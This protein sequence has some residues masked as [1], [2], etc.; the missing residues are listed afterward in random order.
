MDNTHEQTN[1]GSC[2]PTS[3]AIDALLV[4]GTDADVADRYR[5][6]GR[7]AKNAAFELVEDEIVILDTETTG[8]DPTNDDLIEIFAIVMQGT[9]ILERF[10]TFVN[11]GRSIPPEIVELTGITDEDIAG[12]PDPG[13]AVEQLSAFVG[14][15]TVV[16]H[17]A[18]FDRSFIMRQAQA[19]T[20]TT[21]W[22]DSVQ[23]AFIVLPRLKSH[24][25]RD[26][27]R[28]Y[29]VHQPTHRAADD[30]LALA[31]VWRVLLLAVQSMPA[32]L[33]G[34]IAGLSPNTRWPL[35]PI[36]QRA[37]AAHPGTDCNLRNM[38]L[39]RIGA[40][41]PTTKFDAE[42]VALFYPSDEELQEAFSEHGAAGAMYPGYEQRAEQI[43]MALEVADAYRTHGLRAL[44]AGTGVGKSMA[45]LLPTAIFAK[46][47]AVTCGIATKTNAL[48][49]QL[50]YH[51]L[52]R[53]AGALDGL[54]YIAL[55]GYEHYPCLR[56]MERFAQ[57]N[58]EL[59]E[60]DLTMIATLYSFASQTTWG[61]LDSLNIHWARTHRSSI[62]ANPNDCLKRKCPF[63]SRSCFLHG[64][65][66]NAS[67]ADILV[68][69]HALLFRDIQMDN[70]ILPPI[71]HW[72]IDEAHAAESEARRQLSLSVSARELHFTIKRLTSTRSGVLAHIRRKASSLDGG[73][74]LYGITADIDARAA[75]VQAIAESF[76][77]FVKDLSTLTSDTARSGPYTQTT[78]W[79]GPEVRACPQWAALE[80]PGRSLITKLD[81]LVKR[82]KDLVSL[83]EQYEGALTSAQADLTNMTC[84][85][86]NMVQALSLVIEGE[87]ESYVY[88]AVFDINPDKQA[89]C[90]VAEKL[91]I[92]NELASTF[93]PNCMSVVYTSATLST[94]G[95]STG[96]AP[97]PVQNIDTARSHQELGA[98]RLE[99]GFSHF[100][101]TSGLDLVDPQRVSSRSLES[102]YDFD[103]NMTVFLPSDMPEPN[104]REYRP[105]LQAL[106]L[107][108]HEAM[109]GSVLTLFTNRKDMEHFYRVL[110]P[111]L[112]ERGLDL[113]AQVRGTSTKTLRDMFLE[114]REL[115]LL[116]L[117]SFWEGF[118]A[119]GDT[120]RCVI[121]PKLPFGRPTDPIACERKR[122][123]RSAWNRYVL[124]EA[125]MDL[126]QAAGRLIRSSTDSGYL[127]L[128][129]ARLQTKRYG[130]AF[131]NALPTTDIK[132]LSTEEIVQGIRTGKR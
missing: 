67:S 100:A 109:G 55:K 23:L 84:D 4:A 103:A 17:N 39:E 29:S 68:T 51:E 71:R 8:L 123:E 116:A 114:D 11:P 16:A 57:E 46:D 54:H 42:E 59:D 104:S 121:V 75:Q 94:T 62:E 22:V 130:K 35:R 45:Y 48:M 49:D 120:L 92:G 65:R 53:L 95:H 102:G 82:L 1:S 73:D 43:A 2:S 12:A 28:A 50:V 74:M 13:T 98:G 80:A 18:A 115:S 87:D 26:L 119:P 64:A 91:D 69:N 106:M 58:D 126:K 78:L 93:Y 70:G 113:A 7:D 127:V 86:R 90:L 72:V 41:S 33:A 88:S 36:F 76:F 38:R 66:R 85:M 10:E 52:P 20:F 47:N 61:D 122:R 3:D 15:R 30:V 24:R 83:L 125:V 34:F 27:A 89:E 97:S 107:G 108:V 128:A 9:E 77:S 117:R 32:G 112:A 118:D 6:F 110:K 81:G 132:R 5:A 19:G 99:S 14:P 131:L 96:G 31:E 129:D 63:Y 105:C 44:E 60:A 124:P 21:P 37:A 25:L 56:K 101:H 79:V 40:D 111:L